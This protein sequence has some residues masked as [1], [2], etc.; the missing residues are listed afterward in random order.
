MGREL[1]Q[2]IGYF[3]IS[4]RKLVP[5]NLLTGKTTNNRDQTLGKRKYYSR[6]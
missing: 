5:L 1:K 6:S 4:Y 2:P 3:Y